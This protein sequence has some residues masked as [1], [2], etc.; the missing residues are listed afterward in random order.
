MTRVRSLLRCRWA[1]GAVAWAGAG[2][3][4][5][6]V[7]APGGSV[8]YAPLAVAVPALGAWS[9]GMI[10][11]LV[12]AVA[13]R[14]LRGRVSGRLMAHLVLIGGAWVAAF[15]GEGV[16]RQAL[17]IAANDQ[18][19]ASATGGSVNG[20]YWVR[21]TNTSGVSLQVVAIRPNAGVIVRS[22]PPASPE[23]TAGTP[24]AAGAQCNVWFDF[25]LEE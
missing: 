13:Y 24:V 19:M 3:A 1:V 23:C 17:A 18:A 12:A 25:R 14:V 6:G 21:L 16:V 2:W 5:A 11:L 8:D 15:T 4:H 9:L 7:A 22:P 20:T 10:A